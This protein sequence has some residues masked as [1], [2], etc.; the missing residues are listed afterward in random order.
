[1]TTS[2]SILAIVLALA[3]SAL[4]VLHVALTTRRSPAKVRADH[5]LR[6]KLQD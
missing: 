3:S 2:F 5:R 6:R 4:L 1:M